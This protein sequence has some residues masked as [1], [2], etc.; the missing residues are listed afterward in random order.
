VHWD[1]A[2]MTYAHEFFHLLPFHARLKLSLLSC[3]KSI[4]ALAAV[5]LSREKKA[6]P[7][8]LG[9]CERVIGVDGC[10]LM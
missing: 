3:C 7:S 6:Y 5:W 10:G 8:I 4:M 2:N 9:G 1:I